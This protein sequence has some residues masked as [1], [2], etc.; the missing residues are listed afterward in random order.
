MGKENYFV[1]R[2]GDKLTEQLS[3]KSR[4]V[5]WGNAEED[6]GRQDKDLEF[7]SGI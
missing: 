7:C 1:W 5:G 6:L 3:D 2:R 4:M